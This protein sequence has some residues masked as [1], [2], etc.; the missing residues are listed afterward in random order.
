MYKTNY[1]KVIAGVC[2]GI[3]EKTNINVNIIRLIFILLVW[4]MG[5]I[6][7]IYII[8]AIVLPTKY[9]PNEIME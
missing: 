7:L 2:N 8:L 5:V 3:A 6:V 4:G 1:N 9:H